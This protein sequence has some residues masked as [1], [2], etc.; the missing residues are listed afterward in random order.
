[1]QPN[2]ERKKGEKKKKR[3]KKPQLHQV[4][5]GWNR[6][7]ETNPANLGKKR[8]WSRGVPREKNERNLREK[9][10]RKEEKERFARAYWPKKEESKILKKRLIT[11]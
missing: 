6:K 8:R 5:V 9:G 3:I 2:G 4:A 10:K 7:G 1:L 11:L